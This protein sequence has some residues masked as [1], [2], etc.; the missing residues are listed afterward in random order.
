MH[1]NA[2]LTPMAFEGDLPT[3]VSPSPL[4]SFPFSSAVFPSTQSLSPL[5]LPHHDP[6]ATAIVEA[7]PNCS[8]I[9]HSTLDITMNLH[10]QVIKMSIQ[11]SSPVENKTLYIGNLLLDKDENKLYILRSLEQRLAEQDGFIRAKICPNRSGVDSH[12]IAYYKDVPLAISA[13]KNLQ[14]KK[15][16]GS[17]NGKLSISFA[18]NRKPESDSTGSNFPRMAKTINAYSSPRTPDSS[19]TP[20]MPKLPTLTLSTRPRVK[21]RGRLSDLNFGPPGGDHFGFRYSNGLEGSSFAPSLAVDRQVESRHYLGQYAE[22]VRDGDIK[23]ASKLRS[24][25]EKEKRDGESRQCERMSAGVV[26]GGSLAE[27]ERGQ[28]GEDASSVKSGW[29]MLVKEQDDVLGGSL[30]YGGGQK[31]VSEGNS[32][33]LADDWDECF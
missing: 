2:P 11:G 29:G 30:V 33:S 25:R 22:E 14:G 21:V 26:R 7:R 19:R 24:S 6:L 20:S 18:T 13:M 3:I 32:D 16:A 27:F 10:P 12:A 4:P 15:F 1:T 17:S 5:S 8:S 9:L 28:E 23:R 31:E